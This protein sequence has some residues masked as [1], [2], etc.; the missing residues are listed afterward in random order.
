MPI[1]ISEELTDTGRIDLTAL[2]KSNQLL[3]ASAATAGEYVNRLDKD[4]TENVSNIDKSVSRAV[5]TV[6]VRAN[7]ESSAILESTEVLTPIAAKDYKGT[8]VQSSGAVG[9]IIGGPLGFAFGAFVSWVTGPITGAIAVGAG[10]YVGSQLGGIAAEKLANAITGLLDDTAKTQS[11]EEQSEQPKPEAVPETD[12]QDA[13]EN[14]SGSADVSIDFND[15]LDFSAL[16]NNTPIDVTS[17]STVALTLGGNTS[18]EANRNHSV[19]L[20]DNIV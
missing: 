13:N 5:S 18:S 12:R 11:S 1:S 9:S 7:L 20:F 8:V 17:I 15:A 10:T 3:G 2:D 14:C 16:S 19:T 4:Q 6:I